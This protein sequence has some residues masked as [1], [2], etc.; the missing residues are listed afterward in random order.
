MNRRL[1]DIDTRVDKLTAR[2]DRIPTV[3]SDIIACRRELAE[4]R[5]ALENFAAV[6]SRREL[7]QHTA[8]TDDFDQRDH[9]W[10]ELPVSSDD[11]RE[12][13]T[14]LPVTEETMPPHK[15]LLS[16]HIS[17]HIVAVA[18]NDKA[19]IK[20]AIRCPI[21]DRWAAERIS[22]LGWRIVDGHKTHGF[23]AFHEVRP[24][25]LATMNE[26]S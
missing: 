15:R 13:M 1:T 24:F 18:K 8:S 5:E 10:P 20:A 23:K 4:V 21:Q 16:T 9:Q 7:D 17:R 12:L 26:A 14:A 22:M 6:G 19:P 25:V 3:S 11:D 2:C